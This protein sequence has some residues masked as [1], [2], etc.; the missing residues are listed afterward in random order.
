[1]KRTLISVFL[2]L[3][4]FSLFA[5]LPSGSPFDIGD[6][7]DA[8]KMDM[9]FQKSAFVLAERSFA[10]GNM[11]VL[12]LSVSNHDSFYLPSIMP[13]QQEGKFYIAHGGSDL[14]SEIGVI[15]PSFGRKFYTHIFFNKSNM[16]NTPS[17]LINLAG[18]GDVL[19]DSTPSFL[20]EANHL[21]GI[22]LAYGSKTMGFG[23][24]FKV[25]TGKKQHK[26]IVEGTD[27]D[28]DDD[29]IEIRKTASATRGQH[30]I[31]LTPTFSATF[32]NDAH[33][34]L[35][36]DFNYQWISDGVQ[37]REDKA[38][39]YDGN[40]DFSIFSRYIQPLSE[41]TKISGGFSFNYLGAEVKKKFHTPED[42]RTKS[43]K[44]DLSYIALAARLG[45]II[46]IFEDFTS[47]TGA[48]V[49]YGTLSN[50]YKNIH[51]DP[52]MGVNAVSKTNSEGSL[53]GFTLT[54]KVSYRFTDWF[55]MSAGVAKN[56]SETESK[57]KTTNLD[58]N[59]E[60]GTILANLEENLSQDE[61]FG[62]YIGMDFDYRDFNLSIIAN[63]DL[64]SNGAYFIS[65]TSTDQMAFLANL[66][67]TW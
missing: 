47:E 60:D 64:I 46:D 56:F 50:D 51:N 16:V 11:P 24:N 17:D 28:S 38:F 19:D 32:S 44:T 59:T 55:K 31:Q 23:L 53:L 48:L 9:K 3:F 52:N 29:P 20:P 49:T 45:L 62:K 10:V 36:I 41:K 34:D 30:R 43:E 12:S 57:S 8:G 58:K 1:M 65:G 37:V 67:Y 54:Q 6:E 7:D 33:L 63:L 5:A 4:S 26:S 2:L 35:G 27:L 66:S 22:G 25:Y 40:V 21:F 39:E 61:G 42:I 15:L 13:I 14:K 18:Y